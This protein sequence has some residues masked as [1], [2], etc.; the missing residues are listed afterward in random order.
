MWIRS[1]LPR[2]VGEIFWRRTHPK[3]D[4]KE[5]VKE[6]YTRRGTKPSAAE[7]LLSVSIE[8][9]WVRSVG[10]VMRRTSEAGKA[11]SAGRKP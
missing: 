11:S 3:K 1:A 5:F 10:K 9:M 2:D 6:R 8:R 7:E 4:H